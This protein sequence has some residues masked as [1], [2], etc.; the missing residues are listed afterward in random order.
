[1]ALKNQ[2]KYYAAIRI[3]EKIKPNSFEPSLVKKAKQMIQ[4]C[5]AFI[6]AQRD[7]VLQEAKAKEEQGDFKGAYWLYQKAIKIDARFSASHEGARRTFQ[8]L[9]ERA[10]IAYTEAVLSE[11][12]SD[13]VTAQRKFKECL[14]IVPKDSIYFERAQNKLTNYLKFKKVEE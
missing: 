1:M 14:E 3:F 10:K 6:K 4:A 7:P 5:Y 11:S 8:V 2:G 13:F 12:Y 9:N